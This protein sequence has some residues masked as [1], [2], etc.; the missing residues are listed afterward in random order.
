M[1][2]QNVDSFH[3]QAHPELETLELHGFLRSNVCLTCQK[4]SS[5]AEFQKQLSYLNPT[6]AHFLAEALA[7]GA[8]NTENPEERRQKG[9]KTNPDGDVDLPDAPYT[10][11]RYPACPTCLANPPL[12]GDGGRARVE[13][14]ADGAWLPTSSAGVLKPAVVMFGESIS[15]SVKTAAERAIDSSSRLLVLGSSLA[16]YSAWRLVKRAQENGMPIGILS[17]GGARGEE[18][19]FEGVDQGSTGRYAF[20]SNESV[21]KVLPRVVEALKHG[22]F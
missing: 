13:V 11:F 15:S 1:I 21:E 5:R 2:T 18:K 20:R 14:D 7:N 4:E 22:T 6:W 19:F 12:L 3:R 10:T 16:T 17:L 8:L 9:L